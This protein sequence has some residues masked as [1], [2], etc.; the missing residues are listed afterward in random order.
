MIASSQ[1]YAVPLILFGAG[2]MGGAMLEGWL[3]DG[4]SLS[5]ATILDPQ[6]SLEVQ[7]LCSEKRIALNPPLREIPPAKV[8]VLAIKPQTLDA[9]GQLI[10][11]LVGSD[12]LVVSILAG[13]TIA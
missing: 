3:A 2:T 12:T 4:L 13:K 5:S 10:G 11:R 7:T 6:P 9:A 1:A 8:V